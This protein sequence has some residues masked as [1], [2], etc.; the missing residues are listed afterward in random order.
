MTR[1][2]ALKAYCSGFQPGGSFRGDESREFDPRK[3]P[4]CVVCPARFDPSLPVTP[5]D[6][7]P[8]GTCRHRPRARKRLLGGKRNFDL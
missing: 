6:L 3:M 2:S 5:N 4:S 8:D 1:T 7:L